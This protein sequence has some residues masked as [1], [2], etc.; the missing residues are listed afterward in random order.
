VV[1]VVPRKGARVTVVQPKARGTRGV[2]QRSTVS[3]ALRGP[4]S[5]TI[6]TEIKNILDAA[7]AGGGNSRDNSGQL[8][9]L[10]DLLAKEQVQKLNPG[11]RET[12]GLSGAS[13]FEGS[14]VLVA[15]GSAN[16]V[17]AV[18]TEA[19]SAQHLDLS[20]RRTGVHDEVQ[21]V[22]AHPG[23]QA[24]LSTQKHCLFC[25]GLLHMRGYDH[26]PLRDEPWPSKWTH[27]YLGFTLDITNANM[28]AITFNPIVKLECH[29]G[30]RYYVVS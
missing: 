11:S 22:T 28:D 23:V 2:V 7:E 25:Y 6:L 4:V 19:S 29:W 20:Q 18:Q 21:H 17:S 27:D 16:W 12:F 9:V 30:T 10:Q 13:F 8:K 26:G 3:A 14:Q 15:Q 1:R 5:D 24:L